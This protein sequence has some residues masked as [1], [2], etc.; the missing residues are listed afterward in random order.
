MKLTI[1]ISGISASGKT[2]LGTMLA[3]KLRSIGYDNAVFLD[4]DELRERS[5]SKFSHSLSDRYKQHNENVK[6]INE[7]MNKG[8]IVIV[9]TISHKKA[10]RD[11]ARKKISNFFEVILKC[12]SDSCAK[13]D[14]KNQYTKALSGEYNCFPGITEPYEISDHPEL[15]VDTENNDI[16]DAF[17]ILLK[18]VQQ[19]LNYKE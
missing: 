11:D 17:E 5:L 13:R 2:T 7:E 3:K 14:Y 4:G 12:S 8:K 1:W 6:I 19:R 15:V 10:M 18:E 16:D 9:S